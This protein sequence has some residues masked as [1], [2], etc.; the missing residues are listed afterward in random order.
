MMFQVFMAIGSLPGDFQSFV[1]GDEPWPVRS[2]DVDQH[3]LKELIERN[4]H[5]N[6]RELSLDIKKVLINY[7]PLL[8][9]NIKLTWKSFETLCL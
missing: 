1:R 6:T 5:K 3:P 7:L 9:R 8:E 2:F 4:L